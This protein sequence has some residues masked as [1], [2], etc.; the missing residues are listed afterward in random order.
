MKALDVEEPTL[1][2]MAGDV[3]VVNCDDDDEPE[4]RPRPTRRWFRAMT[5][6]SGVSWSCDADTNMLLRRTLICYCD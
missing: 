2:A 3:D 5:S 4:T 6:E 1:A